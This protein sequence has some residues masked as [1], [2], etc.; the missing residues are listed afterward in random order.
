M[1]LQQL[2]FLHA[3]RS[4]FDICHL[5]NLDLF[6]CNHLIVYLAASAVNDTKLAFTNAFTDLKVSEFNSGKIT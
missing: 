1:Y 2:D 3:I 5:V 6:Q 4:R